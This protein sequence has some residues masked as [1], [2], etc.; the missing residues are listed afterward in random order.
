MS[1]SILAVRVGKDRIILD[2]VKPT[3]P[4]ELA[5][6]EGWY[7]QGKHGSGSLQYEGCAADVTTAPIDA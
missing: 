6:A 2:E 7:E 4:I 3:G 1:Q 5:L